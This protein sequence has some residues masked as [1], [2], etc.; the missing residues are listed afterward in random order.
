VAVAV[1]VMDE[2]AF[3]EVQ[4]EEEAE[5]NLLVVVAVH[6]VL[7][8]EEQDTE[9]QVEMQHKQVVQMVAVAEVLAA[10]VFKAGLLE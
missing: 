5:I 3:P 1:V 10:P 6:K 9:I 7:Q 4:V 8:V 2:P